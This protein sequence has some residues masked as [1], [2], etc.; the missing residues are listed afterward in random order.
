[1]S[2]VKSLDDDFFRSPN[3]PLR[4]FVRPAEL[5]EAML[6]AVETRGRTG[7]VL[8]VPNALSSG[9]ALTDAYES[10]DAGR[11]EGSV[12]LKGLNLGERGDLGDLGEGGALAMRITGEDAAS[13]GCKNGAFGGSSTVA[14]VP[15]L[16]PKP[17]CCEGGIV[18]Q[19]AVCGTSGK[20]G[21]DE[22]LESMRGTLS[23]CEF[24][25][26]EIVDR[27]EISDEMT[28]GDV[29]SADEF[30]PF[31]RRAP[32]DLRRR[33]R[34]RR[35]DSACLGGVGAPS[36]RCMALDSQGLSSRFDS[37]TSP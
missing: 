4:L 36:F 31:P 17:L 35:A 21:S 26:T 16:I 15:K 18:K 10:L 29:G 6:V 11:V 24:R 22:S 19:G 25:G 8:I 33:R 28:S 13:S 12:D 30:A 20:P 9:A 1:M 7:S 37:K 2:F 32:R 23:K 3:E 14:Q 27:D 5:L 34:D